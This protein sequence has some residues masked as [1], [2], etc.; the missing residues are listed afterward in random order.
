[1]DDS[2]SFFF[3]FFIFLTFSICRDL[4]QELSTC[5]QSIGRSAVHSRVLLALLEILTRRWP[6]ANKSAG[7]PLS[8]PHCQLSSG[9]HRWR[10]DPLDT[11][12]PTYITASI[13]SHSYYVNSAGIS[14]S[15]RSSHPWQLTITIIT[16]FYW[17]LIRSLAVRNVDYWIVFLKR[18]GRNKLSERQWKRNNR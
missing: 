2:Q 9:S 10:K 1:M 7:T 3:F 12:I 4:S 13:E 6:S 14:I 18:I 17:N 8:L 5:V 15:S 11:N 16:F